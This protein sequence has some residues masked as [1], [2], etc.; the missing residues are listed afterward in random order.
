MDKFELITHKILNELYYSTISSMQLSN[1]T[2]CE[3]MH[4]MSAHQLPQYYQP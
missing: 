3:A 2:Q 4:N 1:E